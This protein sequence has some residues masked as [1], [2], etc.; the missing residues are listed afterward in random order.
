M[1]L[2]GGLTAAG[3]VGALALAA[4][5]ALAAD[6]T[7]VSPAGAYF[8]A[9]LSGSATFSVGGVTVTCNASTTAPTNP[10]GS[11]ANNQ[12]PAANTNP[13]G[14]VS[15]PINPPSFTNCTTSLPLVN[16]TVTTSGAWTIQAQGGASPTASL[17]LPQA[18]LVVRTSGLASCTATAA[19][20]GPAAVTGDWTNGSPAELAFVSEATPVSVVGGFGCP[21]SA[22]SSNFTA[23]YDVANVSD[24]S[25]PIS[26]T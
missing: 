18:G 2:R 11:N 1:L 5:P 14:T 8:A 20:N 16:A 10:V 15:G 12:V 6:P 3:A 26:I 9:T 22:T 21:T 24:P 23:T 4:G 13:D 7:T 25:T 17:V 19:P